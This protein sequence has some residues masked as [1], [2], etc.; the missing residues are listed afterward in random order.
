MVSKELTRLLTLHE[1]YR[2]FV[3]DD[4][5]GAPI[6][7]GSVVVGYPTVGIGLNLVGRGVLKDEAEWLLQKELETINGELD[8]DYAWYKGLSD[9][10][11]GVLVDMRYNLG[12]KGLAAFRQTLGH[13]QMGRFS[14]A[15]DAMMQSKWAGQVKGRAVRLAE[16]MRTDTWPSKLD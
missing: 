14:A 13:I 6:G 15:A 2:Q 8:Q 5:N 12:R 11:K 10:R 1:G 7:P 4:A 9:V 3:Y 16:M